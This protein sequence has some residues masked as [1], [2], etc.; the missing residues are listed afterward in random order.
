MKYFFYILL[1]ILIYS[2]KTDS[3]KNKNESRAVLEQDFKN[4]PITAKLRAY[5]MWENGNVTKASIKRDLEEMKAKGFGGA[6]LCDFDRSYVF[7]NIQAPHGPDFMSKEWREL[8][9]YCLREANGLGLE[10]SLN[11]TSGWAIGGPMIKMKD[12]PKVLT[13][14]KHSLKGPLKF[15]QKLKEPIKNHFNIVPH[16]AHEMPDEVIMD[17]LYVDIATVAYPRNKLPLISNWELKALHKSLHFSAP[18]TKILFDDLPLDSNQVETGI[19]EVIDISRNLSKDGT[20]SWNFP[21]GEWEILRLG[22]TTYRK[23]VLWSSSEGWEGFPLDVFDADIFQ[24]Y[25]DQVVQPL[26][27]DAGELAGVTLKYLH[28]DSWE[29]EPM[30]WTPSFREEFIKRRGYD[31]LPF[32]PVLIGNVVTNRE[33]SNRF[34]NDFRKT[35]G[36]LVIENHYRIFRDNANHKKMLIHPESGGPHAVPIDAQ[37]CLGFNNIPMSEFWAKSWMHRV[38]D[39]DRFF[40]KQPA[41]AAHTYGH[42][43][44]MAEGFTTIGPHWQETIWD[45]LKPSFDRAVCEGMNLLVWASFSCSP[46][47][48]GIPGHVSFSGTHFN[49]NVTWWSRSEPFLS[50]INRCQAML[51]YGLFVAD[52]AYYYGD[53]VPDFAQLKSSDP[54]GILPGYDYDVVTEEVILERMDVSDGKI[55]LPDGMNYKILVLPDYPGFSLPVLRKIRELLYKGAI[56]VGPKPGY[57]NGLAGYPAS[58]EEF[59]RLIN[60]LWGNSSNNGTVLERKIG[61][62]CL[63][64]GIGAKEVLKKLE[65]YQDFSYSGRVDS[66]IDHIHRS[67]SLVDIYF[68][69]N[70]SNTCEKLQCEFRISGKQ[71]EFWDAVSGRKWNVTDWSIENGRTHIPVELSPYGSVFVVFGNKANPPEKENTTPNFLKYGLLK[72]LDGDWEVDFDEKWGGPPSV[73]FK[74][75]YSWTKHSEPGIKYYSGTATYRKKF[76]FQLEEKQKPGIRYFIDLGDVKELAEIRLNG[77]QLG[78]VWCPPFQVEITDA[79]LPGDN[80]LEIDVVNFWPNRIIGDQ[81]LPV[82]QRFTKTNITQFTSISPLAPSGLLGPVSLFKTAL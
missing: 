15:N 74:E 44:V 52:V 17:S 24:K 39:E 36:D 3:N 58:D 76:N 35:F 48:M 1:I 65:I 7:G 27:E 81:L 22:Y 43:L 79:V 31:L 18:D 80:N 59:K 55:V 11:I 72:T 49:P 73:F 5:W 78:I 9:K 50:Y 6:I 57:M 30:N 37:R 71:P 2:C 28:T 26:V 8:Y 29:L 41:S 32:L 77:K 63:F 51:Q 75:L 42:K 34:L 69:S 56:V 60:E 25:W 45:N 23:G 40:V 20:L 4:P 10:I 68:I 14:T 67:E 13:W 47:E 16:R 46:E 54:C 53:H 12:A 64:T 82:S 21:E 70:Q 38:K 33:I 66:K 19:D 62:G 61:K